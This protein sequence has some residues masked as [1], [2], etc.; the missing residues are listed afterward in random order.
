MRN[1]LSHNLCHDPGF[2]VLELLV[3]VSI[4][5]IMAIMAYPAVQSAAKAYQLDAAATSVSGAI[6]ATRYQ[7][8]QQGYPYQIDFNS[9]NNQYQVSNQVPPATSYSPAGSALPISGSQVTLGVGT[10]NSNETGHL[11]L[12]FSPNGGVSV[13]SGQ[14]MPA[15]LTI[16]YNGTT[17]HLTVSTY[18]SVSTTTTTP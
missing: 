11:I 7:A 13:A 12:Q 2:S 5:L 15:V 9:A 6:Q 16:S 1:K 10:A 17:K 4:A 3:V 18:G 8:I 14:A